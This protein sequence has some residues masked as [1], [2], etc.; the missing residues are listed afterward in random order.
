MKKEVRD[1]INE[2]IAAGF[3]F[4]RFTGTGHYKLTH[5]DGSVL[6]LPATPSRGRW[7]QNARA[8]IKRS[9]RRSKDT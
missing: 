5:R 9:K 6:V 2:A 3:T 4:N 1:V 8:T 7:K